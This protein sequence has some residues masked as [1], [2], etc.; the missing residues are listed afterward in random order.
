MTDRYAL[1]HGEVFSIGSRWIEEIACQDLANDNNYSDQHDALVALIR[2]GPRAKDALPELLKLIERTEPEC[3]DHGCVWEERRRLS[4]KAVGAIGAAA[5][6]AVPYLTE[7]SNH[8]DC[9]TASEAMAALELILSTPAATGS[10][11]P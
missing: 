5:T 4:I 6:D 3:E 7:L 11:N 10:S 8:R 1:E 9:M 2:I